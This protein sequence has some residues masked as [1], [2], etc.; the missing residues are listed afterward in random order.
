MAKKV[1]KK[2][3]KT[4]SKKKV[5][6]KKK[7]VIMFALVFVVAVI[8]FL[9]Y[10][11][12]NPK[13]NIT[14]IQIKGNK[15]YMAE[16]ISE[17]V[18]T[19]KGSNIF[20]ITESKIMDNLKELPYIESVNLDRNLP[21]L[22]VIN[23]KERK[24]AFLAYDKEKAKYV[25]LSEDGVI[26]EILDRADKKDSELLVFGINFDD[27]IVLGEK[28]VDLEYNKI[29]FYNIVKAQYVKYNIG[30]EIT[31]I[32]FEN[33]TFMLVLEYNLSV[34]FEEKDLDYDMSILED[35]LKEI[36][37]KAGKIDMTKPDPIFTNSIN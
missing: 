33:D 14:N 22:L 11:I 18:N 37:G 25:R 1:V 5:N 8:T 30:K 26:L 15:Q 23:V 17:K 31:S 32:K 3:I 36:E 10:L 34:I 19:K 2:T 7:I 21:S 16:Q 6:I 20:R 12:T 27:K 9:I 13:F 4:K 28:I 35:I 24:V 29:K